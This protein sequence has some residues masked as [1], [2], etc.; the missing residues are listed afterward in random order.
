MDRWAMAPAMLIAAT[1]FCSIFLFRCVTA[2]QTNVTDPREVSALRALG[3][4]IGLSPPWD[5]SVDPCSGA[6]G[7]GEDTG[8][9]QFRRRSA[10]QCDCSIGSDGVCHV[11]R[12]A[13]VSMNVRGQIPPEIGNFPYMNDLNFQANLITGVIPDEI[14]LLS[15]MEHLTVASNRLSGPI[16]GTMGNLTRLLTL[17]LAVNNFSGTLPQEIGN[18]SSLTELYLDSTGLGGELPPA[19]RNLRRLQT[20]NIFDNNFNGSIPDFLANMSSLQVLAMYGNKFTGPL[21]ASL[22]N[23][24][25]LRELELGEVS[26]GGSIPPSYNRLTSLTKLS[27]RNC[28]LSGF[29]PDLGNL[30]QLTHLDLSFNNLS[31]TIPAYLASIDSLSRLFLG[32]NNLTGGLPNQLSRIVD[33]DVSFNR[34]TGPFSQMSEYVFFLCNMLLIFLNVHRNATI[35]GNQFQVN[36]T[37]GQN[38]NAATCIQDIANCGNVNQRNNFQFA[39]NCGGPQITSDGTDF[40]AD[41]QSSLDGDFYSTGGWVTSSSGFAESFQDNPTWFQSIEGSAGQQAVLYQTARTAPTSLRYLGVGMRSGSYTVHLH[42]AEIIIGT[43]QDGPGVGRRYFDVFIQGDRKLKDF[44][45]REEA[46]GSLRAL[47]RSF[48]AVNV[49]NGVLDI[50]LLW[51]GKG[52]CCAP[53]RS[54]GP[55]ISAIQV[56]PEFETGGASQSENSSRGVKIGVG[57]SV[58][59]LVLFVVSGYLLWRKRH[60]KN[61]ENDDEELKLLDGKLHMFSYNEIKNATAGFDPA[62]LLGKGA[63]GKVYKGVLS[64]GTLVAIK[65]LNKMS[66]NTGDFVN[67][68]TLISTVQH[69]NLVKLYGC[70]T[71][72]NNWILVFEFMENNNLHQALLSSSGRNIHLS[73][74][75]RFNICIGVAR[76]LAYLHEESSPRIIHRDIKATNVL[77]DQALVAKI[78]DFGLARLFEDHQS[79]ISTRV[80]GTMGYLAPEYALRGQLTEKADVYSYG[81]LA[82]E[83]VSGRTNLDTTSEHMTHLLDHAW[84][85]YQNDKLL[86]LLDKRAD[87]ADEEQVLRTIK[88]ALLCT[89]ATASQRPA[90]SKVVA[91]LTGSEEVKVSSLLP[92]YFSAMDMVPR[93]REL[94]SKDRESR[95]SRSSKDPSSSASSSAIGTDSPWRGSSSANNNILPR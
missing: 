67:E 4:S 54:F 89:Q 26:A 23:L 14:G 78:A 71:E 9:N 45:I 46:N 22:A 52:T 80:A 55:L 51:M 69:R 86:E 13:I 35:I 19:L 47:T 84:D 3:T 83:I 11:T 32:S 74:P 95:E 53:F 39:I 81:V 2:Q 20:L 44:N 72:G 75:T 57:I 38:V 1:G 60:R 56:L 34:L 15:N 91:M 48:T 29:I 76:G 79:H 42:F 64:D 70:C 5:F 21:P 17:S 50:H 62:R 6:A 27:L 94:L 18:L 77:L 37:Q 10:I 88:V 36:R 16:P 31:G 73:W 63:F 7:W 90:M 93:M 85:L 24:T 65:Q 30:T 41:M 25:N 12:I 87:D 33:L 40:N 59:L 58:P 61:L 28:Q 92:G 68:A 49:S 66:D 82:L 8:T 43:G